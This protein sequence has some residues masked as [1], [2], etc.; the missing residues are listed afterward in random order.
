[1]PAS[2][3]SLST[4]FQKVHGIFPHGENLGSSRDDLSIEWLT[5]FAENRLR[6]ITAHAVWYSPMFQA[7]ASPSPKPWQLPGISLKQILGNFGSPAQSGALIESQVDLA[8]NG[9]IDIYA[10]T[11]VVRHFDCAIRPRTLEY[12]IKLFDICKYPC[13]V[14]N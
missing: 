14:I 6:T 3:P 11:T 9:L 5:N 4:E 10:E 1:M 2:S 7:H 8:G 13:C 12:F